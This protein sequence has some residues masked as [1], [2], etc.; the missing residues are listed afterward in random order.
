VR[1]TGSVIVVGS[2]GFSIKKPLLADADCHIV[3][4]LQSATVV[5]LYR[6][7]LLLETECV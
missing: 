5:F 1:L 3:K 4:L 2:T 7:V 6:P